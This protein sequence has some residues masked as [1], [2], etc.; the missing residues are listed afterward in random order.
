[1]FFNAFTEVAAEFGMFPPDGLNWEKEFGD[2]FEPRHPASSGGQ[3]YKA[4]RLFNPQ[5][6]KHNTD[7]PELEK[8]SR[9]YA[10]FVFR[11]VCALPSRATKCICRL[12]VSK[13]VRPSL[14]SNQVKSGVVAH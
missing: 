14:P 3:P 13:G 9:V 12:C 4:F 5:Y 1:V 10:G 8:I 7:S 11:K 2:I 6:D